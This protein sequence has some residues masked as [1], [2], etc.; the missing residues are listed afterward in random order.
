L[1]VSPFDLVTLTVYTICGAS[2][3]LLMRAGLGQARLDWLNGH[4][5]GWAAALASLGI[6]FYVASFLLWL[7]VLSRNPV[8]I[9]YP[10]AIGLTLVFV[11]LG[12]KLFLGEVLSPV[13]LG[14]M[15]LILAGIVLVTQ[16]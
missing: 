16:S 12:A 5:I 4:V 2:G 15:V 10:V 1:R 11:A 13:R 7:I 3:L 14:G 8:S 6:A 9:A